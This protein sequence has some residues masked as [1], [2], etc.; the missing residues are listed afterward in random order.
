MIIAKFR[1]GQ[2]GSLAYEW[3]GKN[4]KF[5]ATDAERLKDIKKA[6]PKDGGEKSEDG[7]ASDGSGEGGEG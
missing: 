7:S 4:F 3:H 1:N 2:T 5:V 6:P